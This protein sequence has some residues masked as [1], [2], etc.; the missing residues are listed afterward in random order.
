MCDDQGCQSALAS[1]AC[2]SYG[3]KAVHS[4]V[5]YLL[6]LERPLNGRLDH[7]PKRSK[8]DF[9]PIYPCSVAIGLEPLQLGSDFKLEPAV[10][11]QPQGE[12]SNQ[13]H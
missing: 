10:E 2:G 9:P 8:R 3:F 7:T 6:P 11:Q 4:L 5:T 12:I 1:S 13:E